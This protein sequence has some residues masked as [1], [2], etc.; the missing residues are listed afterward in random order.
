MDETEFDDLEPTYRVFR[1]RT[2]PLGLTLPL[3]VLVIVVAVVSGL[4]FGGVVQGHETRE[5]PAQSSTTQ[6]TVQIAP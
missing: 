1:Q 4:V 6:P 2:P 3:V 5:G